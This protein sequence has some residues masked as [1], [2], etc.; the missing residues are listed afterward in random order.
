MA[1]RTRIIEGTWTC[2][3]CQTP[4]ILGRH[5]KCTQCGNPR[6]ETG[7]ESHFD[8]GEVDAVTGKSLREGV[9]GA[10][11]LQPR[12]RGASPRLAAWQ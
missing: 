7:G 9:T 3:S 8:F 12:Q 11:A 2:T 1:T 10:Q 6:E 5:K 4:G